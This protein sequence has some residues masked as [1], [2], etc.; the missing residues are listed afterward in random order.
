MSKATILNSFILLRRCYSVAVG[1][2]VRG[3]IAT[4]RKGEMRME[5]SSC[6]VVN[7]TNNKKEFFWMRDPKTGY[8]IPEN[9]IGEIDVADLR[10][11]LLSKKN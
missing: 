5:S 9:H 4:M 6:S 3:E 11:N 7:E 8:W 1:N 10:N 2:V